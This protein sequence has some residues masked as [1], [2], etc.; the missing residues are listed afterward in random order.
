M[1][2]IPHRWPSAGGLNVL[3][4]E[5]LKTEYEYCGKKTV[6]QRIPDLISILDNTPHHVAV[7]S[8]TSCAGH[9]KLVWINSCPCFPLRQWQ[10]K[11]E[12]QTHWNMQHCH[13]VNWNPRIIYPSDFHSPFRESI[14]RSV[15]GPRTLN[16]TPCCKYVMYII[17]FWKSTSTNAV[18][19]RD[20]FEMSMSSYI[21]ECRNEHSFLIRVVFICKHLERCL[22]KSHNFDVFM[23]IIDEYTFTDIVVYKVQ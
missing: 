14:I 17:R 19:F 6:S 15:F 18:L 12:M 13:S 8:P 7:L 4:K 21:G 1:L 2:P 11:K 23:L 22:R 16:Y 3:E 20:L 9:S 10:T 5:T